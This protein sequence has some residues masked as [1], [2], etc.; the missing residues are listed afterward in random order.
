M[1]NAAIVGLGNWG[2]HLVRSI[3]GSDRIRFV[4]AVER[5][6]QDAVEFAREHDLLLTDDYPQVLAD[7][8]VH[9]IVI[10]STNSLHVEQAVQAVRA[11][12][13]VFV[14]KPL[15]LTAASAL[16]AVQGCSRAGVTLAVGFNWRF[17]PALIG[18][19]RAVEDGRLGTLLHVEGNYS[20]PSGYRRPPGHWRASLAENPAGGMAARG[21]HVVDAMVNTCGRIQS[22]FARS[23]RRA[24]ATEMDDTTAM[25]IQFEN[26]MTGA[27]ATMMATADLWRL[28]VFG[29]RGWA[30]MECVE[31]VPLSSLAICSVDSAIEIT[32][33]PAP[34]LEKSELESFAEAAATGRPHVV[35]VDDAVHGIRVWEA[36]CESVRARAEIAVS[37]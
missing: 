19:K 37:D 18:L 36:I 29:S 9:A 13:H 16:D 3:R 15:A 24:L 11:G 22:V 12:K 1:I 30:Q 28:Q 8:D 25:L 26:G 17:H 10:A 5:Q 14:E 35:P 27:L 33:Y 4:A 31:H 2:R 20:G 32:R 23:Q 6:P 21:I 7:R 34:N